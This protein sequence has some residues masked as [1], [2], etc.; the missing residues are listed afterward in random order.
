MYFSLIVV[1]FWLLSGE[2]RYH[3]QLDNMQT[4]I[5][6]RRAPR[7]L[8]QATRKTSGSRDAVTDG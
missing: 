1:L 2:L 7:R 5:R 6:K 4:G 3:K 8:R